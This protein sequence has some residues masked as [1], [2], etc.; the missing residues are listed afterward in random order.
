MKVKDLESQQNC[1]MTRNEFEGIC[2]RLDNV[3]HVEWRMEGDW[4]VVDGNK[5]CEIHDPTMTS[6]FVN[7]VKDLRKLVAHVKL[8]EEECD[9]LETI[10]NALQSKVIKLQNRNNAK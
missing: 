9:K 8:A 6:F 1:F 7:I 4:I 2:S 10:N 5:V 3:D